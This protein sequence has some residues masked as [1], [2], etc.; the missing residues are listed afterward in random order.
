[1]EKRIGY[2]IFMSAKRVAQACNPFYAKRER[3]KK[4]IEKLTAE[5]N[6]YDAQISSL[7]AGIRQITGFRVEDIIKK[8]TEPSIREDGTPAIGKDGKPIKTTKYVP[9]DIVT[10]DKEHKQY[11]ITVPDEED[12]STPQQANLTVETQQEDD[13]EIFAA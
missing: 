12:E 3:V 5:F 9:T 1:M 7:E 10:Y 2:D 13:N 4:Q 6:D 11:V 8:V